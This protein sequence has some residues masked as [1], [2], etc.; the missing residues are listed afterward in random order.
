MN[1]KTPDRRHPIGFPLLFRPDEQGELS[2]PSL[3]ASVRQ[4][5][6]IILRTRPGEQLMH[7]GFG[8]GLER[9]IG[10]PNTLATRRRI[11]EL[12][13]RALSE[14]EPRL[15]LVRVDILEVADQP[16]QVRVE[17][18]YRLRRTGSVQQLGLSM[19]LGG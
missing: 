18:I 14:W 3:E 11:Q 13:Q 8:A 16:A 10:Q 19:D 15:E 6:E 5:I 4:S 1:P 7:A 17:I 12:V 9:M 2:F